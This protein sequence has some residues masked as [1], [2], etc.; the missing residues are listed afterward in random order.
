MAG[1]KKEK[2]SKSII[3]HPENPLL[4]LQYCLPNLFLLTCWSKGCW[5]GVPLSWLQ[6]SY[7]T[8]IPYGKI[9]SESHHQCTSQRQQ[10]WWLWIFFHLVKHKCVILYFFQKLRWPFCP[11]KSFINNINIFQK[12]HQSDSLGDGTGGLI[13]LLLVSGMFEIFC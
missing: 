4:T 7:F 12:R 6:I 8:F 2:R 1:L 9:S 13:I 10:H 3:P 5:R 11:W